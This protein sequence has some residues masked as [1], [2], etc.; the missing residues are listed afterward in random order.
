MKLWEK[1]EKNL[2]TPRLKKTKIFRVIWGV[3]ALNRTDN[4]NYYRIT[5]HIVSKERIK[6]NCETNWKKIVNLFL[7]F[8][9]QKFEIKIIFKKLHNYKNT[10]AVNNLPPKQINLV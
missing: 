8:F 7:F 2:P 9:S 5:H 4:Q 3:I 10:R 6:E 1:L